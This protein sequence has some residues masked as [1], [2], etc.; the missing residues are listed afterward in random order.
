[1]LIIPPANEADYEPSRSTLPRAV[2]QEERIALER[3]FRAAGQLETSNPAESAKR[4]ASILARFPEFAEAHYRLARILERSGQFSDAERH[5]QE[6]LDHDGL[7]IR[8]PAP[9]RAAYLR[10]A[11]RHPG[12]ILIDGRRELAAASPR[13]LLDDHVIQDTH[14]PTLRG[15]VALAGAALRELASREIFGRELAELG[16]LDL[17]G[18]A[19]HFQM[20]AERWASMCERTSEHYRR[21]AGYRFD[22]A[23]RLEKSRKYAL[24]ARK[25]RNGEPA[26]SV[27]LPGVGVGER[28]GSGLLREG[29][30]HS[31]TGF[32]ARERGE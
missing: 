8:C 21:V 32:S 19:A 20:D 12:S 22:P 6:A 17:A 5:Y 9:L 3:E 26:D 29:L 28:D 18:C 25:I 7:P 10:V 4:F 2:S 23:E 31:K 11:A 1:V 27:G 14:H 13:R 24:A 16:T 30:G 15:Q